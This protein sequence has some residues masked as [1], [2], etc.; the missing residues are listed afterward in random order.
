M[1]R[2]TEIAESGIDFQVVRRDIRHPRL[3]FR[4]GRLQ[5]IVPR[6]FKKPEELIE[7]HGRWLTRHSAFIARSLEDARGKKLNTG[8]TLGELKRLV[9]DHATRIG[10]Q[11]RVEQPRIFFRKMRS[12]WGSCSS[13]GNLTM[14]SLL[15]FLPERL[16]YYVVL[17]EMVHLLERGHSDK[18]WEIVASHFPDHQELEKELF[19]YWFLIQQES[20]IE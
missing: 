3:E 13:R 4:T 20:G 16:I 7:K 17:H 15:R 12:K 2:Q 6:D 14:N 9:Q 18:F 11:I 10:T 5:L 8:R 1:E 19:A